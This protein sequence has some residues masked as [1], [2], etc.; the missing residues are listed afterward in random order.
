MYV[1]SMLISL[2]P[3]LTSAAPRGYELST[4][5]ALGSA[6]KGHHS[7]VPSDVFSPEGTKL[8]F[9]SADY[10]VQLWDF[11]SSLINVVESGV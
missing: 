8:A 2:G 9:G 5:S 4:G 3:E 10:T 6:L 11:S 1:I 7:W